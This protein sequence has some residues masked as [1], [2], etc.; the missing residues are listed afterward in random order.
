MKAGYN[1][2]NVDYGLT[3]EGHFPDQLM[4]LTEAIDF[5][6]DHAEEYGLDMTNVV[7]FGSSAGA[8]LTGQYGALLANPA[9][10]E[11]LGIHP[12]ISSDCIKCLIVDDAPFRRKSLIGH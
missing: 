3:P 2:V 6:A 4:Q 7:V 8:I 12:K 9:Y 1:F 10:R 11:K 5:C